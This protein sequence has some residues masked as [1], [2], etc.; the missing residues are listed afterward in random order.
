MAT[1]TAPFQASL[2]SLLYV[3]LR[4]RKEQLAVDLQQAAAGARVNGSVISP[5]VHVHSYSEIDNS[6]ILDG[7]QIGRNCRIQRAII[8]KNVTIP[9]ATSIGFDREHDEAR[10]FSVTESGI[11]V[12]GK[13]QVVT[14]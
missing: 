3:D 2:D 5:D 14:P 13:G 10:G 11:T 7:V 1:F 9:E 12:V 6:V 4:M 8:D